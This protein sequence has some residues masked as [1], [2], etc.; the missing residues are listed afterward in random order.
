L[1]AQP[2]AHQKGIH[3]DH[4]DEMKKEGADPSGHRPSPS[5]SL[6]SGIVVAVRTLSQ[7]RGTLDRLKRRDVNQTNKTGRHRLPYC[8]RRKG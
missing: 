7:R 4:T 8:G 6:G 2:T 5:D 1:S 3:K